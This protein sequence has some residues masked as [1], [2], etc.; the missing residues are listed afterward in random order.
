MKKRIS[1]NIKL[2]LKQIYEQTKQRKILFGVFFLF[3]H[4]RFSFIYLYIN[5]ILGTTVFIALIIP[6]SMQ[7]EMENSTS[8]SKCKRLN[9]PFPFALKR[10][11]LILSKLH[12]AI[13]LILIGVQASPVAE[14]F[15]P[16]NWQTGGA[17]FYS[18]TR[19]STQPFGVFRGFLRNLRKLWLG[20]F[21]KTPLQRARPPKAYVTCADNWPYCH[22][23]TVTQTNPYSCFIHFL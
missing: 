8:G 4:L 22:S 14:R 3:S 18:W 9:S 6:F 11:R 1:R 21:R 15:C 5:T 19:L 12:R 20:S 23:L 16:Q 10:M 7:R 17:R 2:L 13:F